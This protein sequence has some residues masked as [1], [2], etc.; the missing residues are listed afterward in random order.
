M[1]P[2]LT[3]FIKQLPQNPRILDLCCGAG[4]ESMRM[5]RLGA[6]V[7]GLDFSEESIR[8]AKELNPNIKFVVEDM[9][10]DYSFLGKFDGCAVIAGLVHLS[11]EKLE[12]AFKMIHKVLYDSGIVFIVVRDGTGKNLKSSYTSIDGED[13]D[14]DFYLHSLEELK[15]YS[16]GEFEF[17]RE[18]FPNE[19]STWKYYIFKR[20]S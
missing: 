11:N 12:K 15:Q 17:D 7:T 4:Y 14:R 8:I 6:D 9:L 5:D 20:C 13:Y 10:S 3:E 2:Y 1:L 18:I 19:E 16:L